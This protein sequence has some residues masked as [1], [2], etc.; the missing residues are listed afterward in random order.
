METFHIAMLLTGSQYG[1]RPRERTGSHTPISAAG[2]DLTE[3]VNV[4]CLD[5]CMRGGKNAQPHDIASPADNMFT[6]H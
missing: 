1:L 5:L 2:S 6:R 4:Q 3:G